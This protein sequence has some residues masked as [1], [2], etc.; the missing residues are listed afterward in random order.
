MK[1]FRHA[2]RRSNRPMERAARSQ[3]KEKRNKQIDKE[4]NDLLEKAGV[5][6]EYGGAEKDHDT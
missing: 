1:D 3:D 5:T 2:G 4:I 6:E